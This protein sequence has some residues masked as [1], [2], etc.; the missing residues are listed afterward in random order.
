[1]IGYPKWIEDPEKLD[2][3]YENVSRGNGAWV[4]LTSDVCIIQY[5]VQKFKQR[6]VL[7]HNF[8]LTLKKLVRQ[9][10]YALIK[11]YPIYTHVKF[12]NF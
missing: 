1:M 11:Q 8:T 9:L 4:Q 7:A 3:Y 10:S 12:M 5:S 2:K 6:K